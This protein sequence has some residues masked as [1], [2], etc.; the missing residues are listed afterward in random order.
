VVLQTPM[1]AS[2]SNLAAS[3]QVTLRIL[4][5]RN[6]MLRSTAHMEAAGGLEVPDVHG[7]RAAR[8][9]AVSIALLFAL[10]AVL[11]AISS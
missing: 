7:Q 9:V 8:T 10:I 1:L 5:R 3:Q 11:Q 4:D 6:A 2:S